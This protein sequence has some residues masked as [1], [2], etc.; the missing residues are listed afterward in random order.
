MR[1]RA[2]ASHQWFPGP[3]SWKVERL[4]GASSLSVCGFDGR[5]ASLGQCGL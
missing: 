5:C 2:G 1:L 3:E 4:E